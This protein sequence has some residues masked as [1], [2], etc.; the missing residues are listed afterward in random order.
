MKSIWK[1][2]ISFGLVNIPVKLYSASVSHTLDFDMLRKGDLCKVHYTRVCLEDGKEIPYEDIVKGYKDENG[3][4][5]VLRD[6]DFE[7]ANLAKTHTIDILHFINESEIDSVYFDKPYYL[8]P[9][10]SGEKSYALLR[11]AIKKSKKA[12]VGRFVLKSREH[13]GVLRVYNDIIIFDQLRYM[14][15]IRDTKELNIPKAQKFSTKEVELAIALINKISHK[16]DPKS[17]K[18]S[19]TSELKK[20]I[21]QKAKGRKVKPQGR[22]PQATSSKNLMTL[23]KASMKKQAA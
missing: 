22:L 11:E 13:F 7:N 18:D 16:F 3:D 17:Y 23:L 20:M 4:Y 1:G 14:D 8:E 19:Y 6:K 9:E 2:S 10:K 21:S 12:A 15:E 5:I